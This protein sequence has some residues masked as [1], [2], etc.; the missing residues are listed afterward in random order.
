MSNQKLYFESLKESRGWYFVEYAPPVSLSPFANVQL[1][2]LSDTDVTKSSKIVSA[3][4]DELSFWLARYDVPLMISAFDSK[5]DLIS[6]G[7]SSHL[8]GRRNKLG[9]VD[10]IWGFFEKQELPDLGPE[11]LRSIYHDIPFRTAEQLRLETEHGDKRT[12]RGILISVALLITWLVVIPVTIEL[13]GAANPVIGYI[14]LIY[15]LFKA[16][17]QLMKLLDKWP[18]GKREKEQSERNRRLEHYFWHCERNPE[19]FER[20]KNENF[21]QEE[22][23][24][25]A[26]KAS[27][28]EHQ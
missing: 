17:V 22:R 11:A 6:L 10:K 9:E 3:M 20:L 14:V 1:T 16:F 13:L 8:M 28:L 4:E 5:G 25:T 23:E 21:D 19:G 18:T 27:E 7:S 12:K 15:S 2:I 26:R 24:K